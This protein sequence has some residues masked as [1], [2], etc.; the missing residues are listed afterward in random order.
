M[1]SRNLLQ[2]H[3]PQGTGFQVADGIQLAMVTGRLNFVWT[4]PIITI[5]TVWISLGEALIHSYNAKMATEVLN[6][7]LFPFLESTF[8]NI[9]L[10]GIV[11]FLIPKD[12]IFCL[13]S[14]R[15]F[16]FQPQNLMTLELSRCHRLRIPGLTSC[17]Q[18]RETLCKLDFGKRQVKSD[19]HLDGKSQS[20]C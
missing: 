16:G 13:G 14:E 6:Q 1:S 2:L 9:C 5:E 8:H 20:P 17:W 12:L 3:K 10:N 7:L 19:N 15:G 11:K 18:E 4:Y